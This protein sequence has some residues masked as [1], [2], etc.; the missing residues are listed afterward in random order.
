VTA[1][2]Y[3]WVLLPVVSLLLLAGCSEHTVVDNWPTYEVRGAVRKTDGTPV[4]LVLVELETYGE[5]GCGAGDL[6][7]LSR[8]MT[9]PN[10]RYRAQQDE[11]GGV[12]SGC[13]HLLAHPDSSTLSEP[14]AIVDLPVD[15]VEVIEGET[16]FTVDLTVP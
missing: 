8:T 16:A 15:S 13:L 4:P 7:A 12:L 10:G 6:S 14:A 1:F 11:P 3:A 2:I 9:D 5:A